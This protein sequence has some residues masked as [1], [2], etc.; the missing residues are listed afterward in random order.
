MFPSYIYVLVSSM[1]ARI[2]CFILYVSLKYVLVSSMFL[3]Y[4]YVLVSSMFPRYS[5][6]VV[7]CMKASM[8]PSYMLVLVCCC[9]LYVGQEYVLVSS[10]FPQDYSICMYSYVVSC[11]K[12]RNKFL[13][14]VC[15]PRKCPRDHQLGDQNFLQFCRFAA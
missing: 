14:P 13:Y 11:M 15:F 3:S 12:A 10:M 6:V 8:F 7:S 2:C 5:Y 1:Y 4:M 9:I